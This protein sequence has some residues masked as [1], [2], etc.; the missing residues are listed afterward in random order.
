[1][2]S[3]L[4]KS[5]PDYTGLTFSALPP[6]R[7]APLPNDLGKFLV[8]VVVQMQHDSETINQW[9]DKPIGIGRRP[10]EREIR[11]GD[12]LDSLAATQVDSPLIQ[13]HEQ[14]VLDRWMK[15]VDFVK[16]QNPVRCFKQRAVE[17]GGVRNA[18]RQNLLEGDGK[19]AG[20]NRDKGKPWA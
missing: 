1:M 14:I 7:K 13:Y 5:W 10:N 3:P 4:G 15:Q 16:E 11:D 19:F 20:K 8:V 18:L 17:L 6:H 12:G 9:A 2:N